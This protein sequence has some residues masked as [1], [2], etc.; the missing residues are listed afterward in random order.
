MSTDVNN[1][2]PAPNGPAHRDAIEAALQD[3]A[4]RARV[5]AALAADPGAPAR[6]GP[7]WQRHQPLLA[8]LAS[9]A[10]VLLAFLLPSIQDQWNL[11]RSGKVIDQYVRI[12]NDLLAQKHYA[13]AEKAIAKAVE[14]SEGRRL[15]LIEA[16]LRAH[17]QRVN[18]DPAWRGAVPEDISE[19]DFLYLL[20]MQEG[21]DR[22][23]DRAA[24]LAAYGAWLASAGRSS[25]AER[26]LQEALALDARNG[27]AHVNLGNL[28]DDRGDEQ[29]AEQ[30]YR[31]A[32]AIDAGN[33]GAQ[34]DLGLLL[35]ASDRA[36]D[37]EAP[38]RRYVALK[39]DD[40]EGYLR[41]AEALA[42][43]GRTAE[44]EALR[45]RA[46]SPGMALSPGKPARR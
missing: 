3:P 25:D 35:L 30:E 5:A 43:L 29:A 7:A 4:T 15:D 1:G 39:A 23:R 32:I 28:F 13:S 36:A 8:G 21:S 17:V 31:R 10:V 16:E 46:A 41:L 20:A 18:E 37:A 19:G 14:M 40:P 45:A 11:Y 44:A 24:T 6:S 27:D 2:Q 12:G 26:R 42:A 9:G 33:P 34:Y 38:L 22:A